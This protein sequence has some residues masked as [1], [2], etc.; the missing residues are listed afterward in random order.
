[1]DH[2]GLSDNHLGA[3]DP[4]ATGLDASGLGAIGLGATDPV[5]TAWSWYYQSLCY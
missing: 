3:T 2:T 1:M 4:V 5:A